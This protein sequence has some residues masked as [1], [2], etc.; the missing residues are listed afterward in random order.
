MVKKSQ[1]FSEWYGEIVETAGLCDKRYPIKGMNIWTP[2]GWKVMR[3]ID[4]LIR[5]EFD[6]AAHSEVCFPLLIPEDQF[7]K[8]KEHIKGF[9]EQVY[10]VTHAGASPLD[11]KLCLRPTSE[12]AIYPV[13][14]LWVRSHADLP[15]KIYQIVDVFRYETKQTRAFMRVREIH[16][17]ESHTCHSDF[18]DAERQMK[19]NIEIMERLSRKLCLPF[20][21]S[22]RP[23]WDKFAG[24][25]YSVGVD[26]VMPAGR[27][28]QI[29]GIHQYRDNFA[30]AF[31]ITYEDE[32]GGR[33]HV[34]QTTFGMSERLVGAVVSVHGD[35][36][37]LV[38]PPAIAPYQVVIVPVPAKGVQDMV[39]TECRKLRDVLAQSG[40][41]VHLDLRDIRPGNK[42]YDWE[43]RG[44]PLRAE[45]GK[46][47]IDENVIVVARRDTMKKSKIPV[48]GAAERIKEILSEVEKDLY[49]R[50]EENM[51][52]AIRRI[53]TMDE[54]GEVS[55]VLEMYW[56]GREECGRKIEVK[57]DT[58]ILGTPV[59]EPGR[60]VTGPEP[61]ESSPPERAPGK[62]VVCDSDTRK[63]IHVAR[64][65]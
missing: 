13:F 5:A 42:Y 35:D 61:G 25:H 57:F 20:I 22:V 8:E 44:V 23:D 49:S 40:I 17:F 32:S 56:C 36:N 51:K 62:C 39:E 63:I 14:K 45:L 24:A 7:A 60:L 9:D 41:R 15:L 43:L 11:I 16:F 21:A 50:A 18:E 47:D 30:K 37:G 46:R 59:S 3:L 54:P 58:A 29:G 34:H 65:Y 6:A 26:S 31:D 28:L 33:K 52:K 55:S 53:S 38:L 2:Y 10:W 64:T 4:D 19:Q 48:T 27:T 12:T 1:D